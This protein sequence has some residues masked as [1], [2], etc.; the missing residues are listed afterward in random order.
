M[1]EHFSEIDLHI[2]ELPVEVQD[3]KPVYQGF[4]QEFPYMQAIA[5]S[6]RE[7]NKALM[8][9]YYAYVEE[10][11]KLYAQDLEEEPMTSSLLSYEE[12][13]KY[14]DGEQFDGFEWSNETK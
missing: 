12:L 1:F 5:N 2:V 7:L 6:K 14:Y 4:I 3:G 11:R 13:L 8:E 9:Q 10:Q